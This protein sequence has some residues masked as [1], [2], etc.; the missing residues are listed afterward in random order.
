MK[1]AILAVSFGTSYLDSLEK[2]IAAIEKDLAAAFPDRK[3]YRAFT[4]GMII[5][6]L[7]KRD[8]LVIDTV[9][10]ALAR[11]TEEGYQDVVVQSTHVINGEEWDKLKAQ[12]APFAGKFQR[13]AFGMP[14]LTGIEDYRALTSALLRRLP[15]EELG[16]AIVFMGHGSEHPANAVYATLEYMFHDMGRRDIRVGTVEG[17][18]GF[19]EV[20]RRLAEQGNVR[21]VICY[22]LMVVAGDHVKNDLAGEDPD[23]WRSMLEAQ[24]YHVRCVLEGLGEVPEIRAIFTDHAGKALEG[25][26]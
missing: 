11:L 2:T 21:K 16:T 19:E 3:L 18:P 6:K 13:L 9:P 8:G 15:A 23:S 14:L 20:S 17:Y 10:E 24:G 12:A 22:P 5:K 25:T 26:P 7:A 1:K 4:S